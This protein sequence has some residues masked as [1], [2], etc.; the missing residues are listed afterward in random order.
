MIALRQQQKDFLLNH[1]FK[2]D[3]Y[4]GWKNIAT[5]LLEEGK[6]IV[7]GENCIWNGGIGNFITISPTKLAVGCV[8]YTFD[9]KTLLTTDWFKDIYEQYV[10]SLLD[11]KKQIEIE[12]NEIYGLKLLSEK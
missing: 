11:R 4:P 9:L 8:L 7:P 6:C 1:F 10:S 12:Y 3:S 2:N 5:C